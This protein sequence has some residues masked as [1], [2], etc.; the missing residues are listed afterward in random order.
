MAGN[1]EIFQQA[2]NQGHSAAWDQLWDRAAVFY[3]Q[4]LNEFPDHPKALMNLGLALYE[5]QEYDQA[6]QYY[7]RAARAAQEDPVPMEKVAQLFERQGNITQA[8]QSYLRAAELHLKNRDVKKAIDNWGHVLLLDPEDLSAHSRLALVYERMGD[9]ARASSEYLAVAS[10]FQGAGDMDRAVSS[11]NKALQ[12]VPNSDE[13]IQALAT[14]RDFKQ[15]PKPSRPRRYSPIAHGSSAPAG[16]TEIGRA[17]ER[18][19]SDYS[20]PSASFDDSGRHAF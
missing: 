14:L 16:S 15:L 20:S 18:Y 4:A 11:V 2:M 19:G 3:R 6:L 12:L 1:Q 9:G 7:Q 8:T 5:M 13:A 10:L 17:I